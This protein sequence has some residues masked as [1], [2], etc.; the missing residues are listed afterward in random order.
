MPARFAWLSVIPLFFASPLLLHADPLR[1]ATPAIY[2]FAVTGS[3]SLDGIAFTD[4]TITFTADTTLTSVSTLA[5][6]TIDRALN[7]PTTVSVS[8]VGSDSLIDNISFV[9]ARSGN[10]NAGITDRTLGLGLVVLQGSAFADVSMFSNAGPVSA[11]GIP[12]YFAV[13]T[14]TGNGSLYLSDVTSGSY[15]ALI[16]DQP[17][18]I[19]EP[20]SLLLLGTGLVGIMGA[21][22]KRLA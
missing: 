15:T 18:A 20:S 10:P 14:P 21:F 19:P 4:Q 5:S 9:V 6:G 11:N 3:G 8:G 12:N 13:T 17:A 2:T 16:G 22:R 1:P 7:V